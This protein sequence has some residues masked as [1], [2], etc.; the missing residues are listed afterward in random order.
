MGKAKYYI[1][2]DCISELTNE[3]K[4]ELLSEFKESIQKI[5]KNHPDMNIIIGREL[6]NEDIMEGLRKTPKTDNEFVDVDDCIHY[7]EAQGRHICTH[8][9]VKG[10]RCYGLCGYFED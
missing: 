9:L 10:H 6:T 8:P 5:K 1:N 2:V 3:Q 4:M 7:D